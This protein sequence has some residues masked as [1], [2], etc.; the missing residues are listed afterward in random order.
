MKKLLGILVL[1]LLS[2]NVVFSA[3]IRTVEKSNVDEAWKVDD[4][5]IK[6]ECFDHIRM[7]GDWYE[8]YYDEYFEKPEGSHW[9]DPNFVKFTEE[10][11]II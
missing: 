4:K 5:F 2:Y 9:D 1:G 3:E 11:G 8:T 7:S 10:V 6:P